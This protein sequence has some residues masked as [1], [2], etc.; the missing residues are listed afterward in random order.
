MKSYRKS[1]YLFMRKRA[2]WMSVFSN[3]KEMV[4]LPGE[5]DDG[6]LKRNL[7][8]KNS[9]LSQSV[10]DI[11]L[12]IKTKPNPLLRIIGFRFLAFLSVFLCL[13]MLF[14]EGMVIAQK[15]YPYTIPYLVIYL[16]KF[17]LL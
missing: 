13:M 10:D 1:Y 15:L 7:H 5:I 8:L 4:E 3:V 16:I 2:R 6:Y 14:T 9:E 12:L 11:A 17:T